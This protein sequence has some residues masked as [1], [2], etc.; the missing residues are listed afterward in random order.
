MLFRSQGFMGPV[1]V[2]VSFDEEG[3][4]AQVQIGGEGFKETPGY[5]AQALE[6]QFAQRFIGK[7]PPLAIRQAN[8]PDGEQVVDNLVNPDTSTGAT[9]TMQAV[10]DAINE[11]FENRP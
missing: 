5:G 11:A 1:E 9:A 7:L 8:Q 3:R 6:E 10:I 2:K 4:I